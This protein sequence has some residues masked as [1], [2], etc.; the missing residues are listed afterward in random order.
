VW[1]IVMENQDFSAINSS[2]AP[3]TTGTLYG[4]GV[5]MDNYYAVTHPSCP[6]YI[7]MVGGDTFGI[8][9]DGQ[10]DDPT[11]QVHS[12]TPNVASQL[13]AAGLTWHEY[14]ESQPSPCGIADNGSDATGEFASKHDPMPHFLITQSS[15]SCQANDVSYDPQGSMPGMAADISNGT[16][17]NYVFIS[18]NLCDDGHDSCPPISNKV[19]QQDSWLSTNV[20]LIL[21]SSA[22]ADN[23]VLIITWDE[24]SGSGNVQSQIATVILSP[25]LTSPGSSNNSMYTH[26]SMLATIEAGFGLSNLPA[27]NG[28]SD[29]LITDIWK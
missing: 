5:Q 9:A 8:T 24:G 12:P 1:I 19:G 23:G 14:S 11:Y 15:S 13:E 10:A 16:F 29:A 17:F 3:Y 7:A 21:N 4:E 2:S 20:S 26:Y 6:N 18:P 28:H 25:M 22:Y 27:A